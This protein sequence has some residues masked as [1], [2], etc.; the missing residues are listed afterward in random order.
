M[1]TYEEET[2]LVGFSVIFERVRAFGADIVLL[3]RTSVHNADSR[4]G[5]LVG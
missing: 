2:T 5:R 3:V 4:D 1:G